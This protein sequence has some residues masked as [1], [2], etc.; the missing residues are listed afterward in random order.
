MPDFLDSLR[1]L[2]YTSDSAEQAP[3]P[4]AVPRAAAVLLIELA[5]ADEGTSPSE[6][7]IIESAM[8]EKFD[9][10]QQQ[11]NALL[12]EAEAIQKQATS[13]HDYTHRLRTSLSAPE[14]GELIEWLWRVAYADGHLD[15]HEEHLIR[16]LSDLIGVPHQEMIR[17]KH[18]AA[19]S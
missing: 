3:S 18:R 1:Q 13:M 14:R 5:M 11:L 6:R 2:I 19:E 16:R 9:L 15:R 10:S 17:R 7:A 8:R 4:D 12:T